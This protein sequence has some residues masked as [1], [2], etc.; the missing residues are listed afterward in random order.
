MGDG[1]RGPVL[2][3]LKLL[4]LFFFVLGV[5]LFWGFFCFLFF[6]LF[7]FFQL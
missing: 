2:L 7:W 1:S 6:V 5:L 4:E 3:G